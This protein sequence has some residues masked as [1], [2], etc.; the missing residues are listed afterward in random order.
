VHLHGYVDMLEL[1]LFPQIDGIE[2]AEENQILF[3]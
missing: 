3:Q 2:Q 1:F